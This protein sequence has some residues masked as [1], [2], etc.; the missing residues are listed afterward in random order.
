MQSIA[1][2]NLSITLRSAISMS[3]SLVMLAV[4]SAKL[5]GMIVVLIPVVLVPLIVLGRRVRSQSRTSQDRIADTSSIA[6]ETLNA[7][8]TVQAFT[9][10][11]VNIRRFSAAVEDSFVAA[12]NRTKTRY[13]RSP[14][15]R[16]CSCSVRSR[17]CCG[18]ALTRWCAAR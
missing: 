13:P 4:T 18:W 16:R 8:Q 3:G 15:W 6:D 9:L 2:V 7:I 17:S 10:E 5:T 1:G 14:R 12:V 11:D